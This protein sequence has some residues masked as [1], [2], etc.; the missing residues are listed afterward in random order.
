MSQPVE[1]A[2]PGLPVGKDISHTELQCDRNLQDYTEL[3]SLDISLP[4][5][6]R[7]Q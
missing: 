4:P 2:R 3:V 6:S 7:V 5:A 1:G